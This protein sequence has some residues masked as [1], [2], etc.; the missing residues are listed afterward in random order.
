M[1]LHCCGKQEGETGRP[2]QIFLENDLRLRL[3]NDLLSL[4][5][6]RYGPFAVM[7]LPPPGTW[8]HIRLMADGLSVDNVSKLSLGTLLCPPVTLIPFFFLN[9]DGIIKGQMIEVNGIYTV[10]QSF[11][12]FR[13]L[14]CITFALENGSVASL[15]FC[16]LCPQTPG[17]YAVSRPSCFPVSFCAPLIFSLWLCLQELSLCECVTF[18][19]LFLFHITSEV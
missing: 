17:L 5:G 12:K 10:L 7:S 8:Q 18:Y 15:Q 1:L 13:Y 11:F 4:R 3:V 2:R 19:T 14:F 6:K 9:S 16:S